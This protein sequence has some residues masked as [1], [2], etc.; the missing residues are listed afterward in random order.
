MINPDRFNYYRLRNVV[1]DDALD[2]LHPSCKRQFETLAETMEARPFKDD[3]G[4]AW[5]FLPFEVYRHPARQASLLAEGRTRV[6]PYASAHQYGMAVDFVPLADGVVGAWSWQAPKEA[7]DYLGK[8]AADCGLC[9]PIS[10]D[11]PH[12]ESPLW[13]AMAKAIQKALVG[14]PVKG[15]AGPASGRVSP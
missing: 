4:K 14:T 3:A 2:T 1:T 7:W 12:I 15:A 13:P 5:V 9:Q 10:W 11:R 6:G 8:V